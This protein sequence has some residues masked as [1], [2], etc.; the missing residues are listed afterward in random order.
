MANCREDEEVWV[1]KYCIWYTAH[2]KTYS[3]KMIERFLL[4]ALMCFWFI[5][6]ALGLLFTVNTVWK[7][8]LV[9]VSFVVLAI[10]KHAGTNIMLHTS[11]MKGEFKVQ[12]IL[13]QLWRNNV[14]TVPNLVLPNYKGDIDHVAISPTGIWVI[15]T[16]YI[17]G[18][19][20]FQNGELRKNGKPFKKDPLAQ[21]YRQAKV[22][23]EY[24]H[25][26]NLQVLVKPVLVF[27]HRYAKVR[28][29]QEPQKGVYVVG[30][31][32]IKG[33]I[34][35]PQFTAV[36]DKDQISAIQ[37]E[38]ENPSTTSSRKPSV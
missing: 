19:I 33:L 3:E 1:D 22:V 21:A 17:S 7:W 24:L 15:E 14:R 8:V 4:V 16:K 30:S 10:F 6:V 26:K 35:N 20:T 29:H 27:A 23:E 5:G 11:G 31:L 2:M 32:G 28:F 34:L 12:T 37:S 13:D 25:E 38:L 9:V 18:N 36:Y